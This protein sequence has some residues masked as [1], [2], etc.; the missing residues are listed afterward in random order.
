MLAVLAP[1]VAAT[2]TAVRVATLLPFVG[3]ALAGIPERAQVVA[4][5]RRD[6]RAPLPEGIADLGNPHS[7]DLEALVAAR[8]DLV[9]GERMLHARL[10]AD[11]ARSGAR[12]L[13]LDT[14][15]VDSTLDGLVAL[16]AA[17]GDETVLKQRAA[18]LRAELAA[19]RLERP[20][21][22]LALFGTP[23][24][25]YVI[26]QRTWIGDLLARL[27]FELPA[28]TAAESPRFPGFV[29]VSDE[30]L[31]T[32]RPKLVLLVA[33]GDPAA[34]RE[35]LAR[36]TADGG[37]W[38]AVGRAATRGVEVLDPRLF[39]SNPGF[40]MGRAAQALV[41]LGGAAAPAVAAP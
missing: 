12:V 28:L 21:P 30:L 40:G 31:V 24:A 4:A 19:L 35:A 33:H 10:E 23:D 25:F 37:P 36:K 34:L 18:A 9:V 27:G 26:T 16:A 20:V 38:S 41:A 17:V 13:L 6:L 14:S 11:L 32:L 2:A 1:G 15:G 5:A 22:V 3:D 39:A 8:P 7:P 29:P